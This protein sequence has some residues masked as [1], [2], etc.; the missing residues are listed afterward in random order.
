VGARLHR[1]VAPSDRSGMGDNFISAKITFVSV[2]WR[3]F[4]FLS[5]FAVLGAP[6]VGIGLED[7]V[8]GI[9]FEY[10]FGGGLFLGLTSSIVPLFSLV[11]SQDTEHF[12]HQPICAEWFA[13][14]ILHYKSIFFQIVGGITA[15]IFGFVITARY[16]MQAAT[17]PNPDVHSLL[18][19]GYFSGVL[20]HLAGVLGCCISA[21]TC[22]VVKAR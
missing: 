17:Q 20:L 7:T 3:L 13:N 11:H 21:I 15:A 4:A 5:F 14:I 10:V 16:D 2:I 8:G 22:R 18:Q 1:G 19:I 9:P 12:S 6:I